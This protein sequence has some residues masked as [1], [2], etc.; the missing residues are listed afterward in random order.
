[1]PQP[2]R[3]CES[4][5]WARWCACLECNNYSVFLTPCVPQYRLGAR[6]FGAGWPASRRDRPSPLSAV[7]KGTAVISEA[8]EVSTEEA[9]LLPVLE[10]AAVVVFPPL[11]G[12]GHAPDPGRG[13]C[14][15]S[16]PRT[17]HDEVLEAFVDVLELG[18]VTTRFLCRSSVAE[19]SVR[20]AASRSLFSRALTMNQ[21][22]PLVL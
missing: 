2:R 12:N 14:L 17:R 3:R 10:L 7:R 16:Q 19:S 6:G 15:S 4:G 1:M 22:R 18:A 20:T 11:A 8:S 5:W 9:N 13:L 21:G